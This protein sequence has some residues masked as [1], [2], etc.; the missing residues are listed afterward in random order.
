[1][2]DI[3]VAEQV[4]DIRDALVRILR[5]ADHDVCTSTPPN[6]TPRARPAPTITSAS[7]S[8]PPTCSPGLKRC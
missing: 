2:A 7:L 6:A 4:T 5:R 1:M 8:S 3:L